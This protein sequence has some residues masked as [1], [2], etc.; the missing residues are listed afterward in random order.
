[1][2]SRGK[3]KGKS[4]SDAVGQKRKMAID[5]DEGEEARLC[6]YSK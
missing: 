3:A 2:T 1:L 5:S 6:M 4:K